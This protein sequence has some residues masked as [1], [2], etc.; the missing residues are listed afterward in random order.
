MITKYSIKLDKY[1]CLLELNSKR[2]KSI[3]MSMIY[4]NIRQASV[5]RVN[6][7][8]LNYDI[9]MKLINDHY[10]WVL[11][12]LNDLE[13]KNNIFNIEDVNKFK[14]IYLYGIPYEVI[15]T[16]N[17]NLHLQIFDDK[18]YYYSKND[19]VSNVKKA[20]E[21]VR[22]HYLDKITELF[23]HYRNVFKIN[24]ELAYKS[25]KSRHGYCLFKE[26]KI[27]LSTHLVHIPMYAI[28]YVIIHE[29]CH[30]IVNNHSKLFYLEVEK[31]CKDY[32]DRIKV[33]KQYNALTI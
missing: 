5:I 27:V 7:Y 4:D 12:R 8:R 18:F 14:K 30:F 16:Q 15:L 17:K 3:R 20:I 24:S 29:F 22:N 11:K 23:D 32:K 19:E 1:N 9:A 26:N 31:Y 10:S 33:L 25:M 21:F 13:K 6:G 28:E 2:M